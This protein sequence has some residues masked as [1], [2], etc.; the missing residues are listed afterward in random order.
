MNQISDQQKTAALVIVKNAHVNNLYHCNDELP[1][2]NI[3][4]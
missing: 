4:G 2:E 3:S 1:S